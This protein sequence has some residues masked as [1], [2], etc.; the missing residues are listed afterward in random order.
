M[1]V[2]LPS[3]RACSLVS[4]A[5]VRSCR[6]AVGILLKTMP[7][8]GASLA[9]TIVYERLSKCNLNICRLRPKWRLHKN[10]KLRY[11]SAIVPEYAQA[12]DEL[13]GAIGQ[14]QS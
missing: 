14:L 7:E 3:A 10:R 11:C 8:I 9:R 6:F 13:N 4:I 2:C 12:Q 5:F 1:A